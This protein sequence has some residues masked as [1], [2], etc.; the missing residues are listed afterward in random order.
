MLKIKKNYL[1]LLGCLLAVF[2]ISLA[3]NAADSRDQLQGY[4]ISDDVVTTIERTVI[5][6]EIPADAESIYPYEISK[7]E[8]NG[9]GSWHYGSGV[10][11][12]RLL[13]LMPDSYDGTSVINAAKLLNF[14]TLTDIHITDEETPTQA[15]VVGYKGGNSSA[16]SP[17][18]MYSTQVLDAAVQ[19]IN[20]LHRNNSFDF[21]IALGDAINNAQY[22]E[23]RMY[24]DVLDGRKIAPDS[25]VK[26]DPIPGSYN[27][28]QDR[29]KAAG[30]DKSIPWYQTMGNHDQLYM[31]AGVIN[32]YLRESYTGK[33]ILNMGNIMTDPLGTDSRGIYNG[34][35]DGSTPTGTII[36][37]G[38]VE[39]FAVPPEVAAAD[40]DRHSLT[41]K[42]WIKEFFKTNSKPVGHGFTRDN[43][44]TGFA[45]Y[46]FEPKA[47]LPI[48]VIVLDD[49]QSLS[50]FDI[51]E[52]GYLDTKRFN[53]LIS[54]LDKGQAEG[55]LMVITAHMPL[56]TMNMTGA[57]PIAQEEIIAKL[58]TYPNLLMWLSGH[59]HRNTVKAYASPDSDHPELGFWHVE[60][61]SLRDFPQQ[62]RTFQIDRNNDNTISIHAIDVDIAVEEGSPADLSRFYAVATQQLFKNKLNYQPSGVYNAELVKQLSPEMQEVIENYGTPID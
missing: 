5:P 52:Q 35:I 39:D 4:S 40:P 10:P 49:T 37:A 48:K 2:L 21:G 51:D 42:E 34:S 58:N 8:E 61:A 7:Y 19:T 53:W 22:N 26:D 31:G 46:S 36:G 15:I 20:A 29:Y 27:D 11:E 17:V 14:F 54:E 55:K 3:A 24:I 25:G 6:D 33:E 38:A 45:C 57:F 56:Y 23:L 47:D 60:T 59:V 50:N 30:L 44:K 62:F 18:I 28:Y 9:Y 12:V 41:R 1:I 13:D 32:A 43:K 16:Y